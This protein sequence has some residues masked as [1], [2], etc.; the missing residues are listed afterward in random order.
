MTPEY[1]GRIRS[2]CYAGKRAG[3][4]ARCQEPS[5]QGAVLR[6]P[7][8]EGQVGAWLRAMLDLRSLASPWSGCVAVSARQE[9]T[10]RGRALGV[11]WLVVGV[12]LRRGEWGP[13][14]HRHPV[15]WC[16]EWWPGEELRWC[17]GE[18]GEIPSLPRAAPGPALAPE[19]VLTGPG[20]GAP[21]RG[22]LCGAT[23]CQPIPALNPI[24]VAFPAQRPSSCSLRSA[25]GQAWPCGDA[26]PRG[27]TAGTWGAS[28][29]S[30]LAAQPR[31]P[32]GG[33]VFSWVVLH[34]ADNKQE[35]VILSGKRSEQLETMEYSA[36][37][38]DPCRAVTPLFRDCVLALTG[39]QK[40]FLHLFFFNR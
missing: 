23:M 20:P 19:A 10:W 40:G 25:P 22:G 27:R 31:S 29:R 24:T 34:G 15:L 30:S 26:S 7:A 14:P 36:A 8:L 13:A 1:L 21:S 16:W 17:F 6:K 38:E 28:A 5:Q 2:S 18:C 37:T 33:H 12:S 32:G 35:L 4:Q 9:G 11:L 3:R 39:I